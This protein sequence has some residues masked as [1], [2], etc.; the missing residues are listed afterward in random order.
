MA[1]RASVS[2]HLCDAAEPWPGG[3]RKGRVRSRRGEQGG[4]IE[5]KVPGGCVHPHGRVPRPGQVH[6]ARSALRGGERQG[7]PPVAG[8]CPVRSVSQGRQRV[9][10]QHGRRLQSDEGMSRE[11]AMQCP[12]RGLCSGCYQGLRGLD[13]VSSA[14]SV[15]PGRGR[16]RGSHGRELQAVDDVCGEGKVPGGGG[17]VRGHGG[18]GLRGV[19]GLPRVR[20][21][22]ARERAVR[23]GRERDMP[24]VQA[25][26]VPRAVHGA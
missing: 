15:R 2:S 24:H 16:L 18:R 11:R 23:G 3:V 26:C 4:T 21:V 22:Q 14:R 20:A 6:G 25:L 8:L 19:G 1:R 12:E 5:P 10:S 9:Q 7:L 17:C 13:G